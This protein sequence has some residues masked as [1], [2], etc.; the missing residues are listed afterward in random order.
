MHHSLT[1]VVCLATVIRSR[2]N[3]AMRGRRE[4]GREG[5]REKEKGGRVKRTEGKGREG[6]CKGGREGGREGGCKGGRE[7]GSSGQRGRSGGAPSGHWVV[8]LAAEHEPLAGA[9]LWGVAA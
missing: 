2:Q 7:G 1:S 6:G 8:W 9:P 3:S 5:G 4:G